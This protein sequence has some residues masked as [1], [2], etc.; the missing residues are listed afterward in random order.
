VRSWRDRGHREVWESLG[1]A[2]PDWAVLTDPARRGG[3]WAEDMDTFYASG[4]TEVADV[5]DNLPADAGR[6]RAMDWGSGTG[7]L[8]FALAEQYATVTAVDVSDTM[9][10]TLAQRAQARGV[11]NVRGT[12]VDAVQPAG[13]QD[14]VL[15]L[16]VLQHLADPEAVR[17]ALGTIV[18]CL[19]VG[20]WAVVEI[21]DTALTW[22]ARIQPRFRAYRA[23]RRVGVDPAALHRHGLSGISMVAVGQTVVARTLEGAGGRLDS[24]EV[25]RPGDGYQYV[26]YRARRVR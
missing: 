13:D 4:V 17:A 20:G 8:T 6:A 24:A 25:V 14:L 7:R 18:G 12:R 22:R 15:C 5:L 9:L 26:R 16:L 11:G 3:G 2:D 19:R 21:P 23:L 1:R 10:A